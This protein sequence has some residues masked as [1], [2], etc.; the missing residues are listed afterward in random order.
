MQCCGE[1]FQDIG[2]SKEIN[3]ASSSSGKC[4]TCKSRNQKLIDFSELRDYFE[5]LVGIY[6]EDENGKPLVEWFKNDWALFVGGPLEDIKYA[7]AL[8]AEVLDDGEITRKNFIPSAQWQTDRQIKWDELRTELM[9]ENRFFPQTSIDQ[10][11]LQELLNSLII[12]VEQL[13]CTWFRARI[14][15]DAKAYPNDKMGAPP[16]KKASSGRANPV[17]IPYLYLASKLKTALS[18]V[19]PHPGD[20]VCVAN[21]Q[22]DDSLKIADLRQPRKSISPFLLGDEDKLGALREDISFLEKLGNELTNPIL[23][24]AASIEYVPSQYLCEFI[25]KIGFDGVAYRSSMSSGL[26]LALFYS[27]KAQAH[28]IKLH[29]IDSVTVKSSECV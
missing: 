13:S 26:N 23:P 4:P 20:T 15:K 8:L 16:K 1:C 2:L 21:F 27:D 7:N 12:Q 3:K 11:R 6:N 14:T 22:V 28:E 25:K 18:E 29:M 19:R 17:G 10:K 24:S 9:H 5:L